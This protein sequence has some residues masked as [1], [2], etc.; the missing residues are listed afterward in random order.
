MEQ[1]L[2][3]NGAAMMAVP[4]YNELRLAYNDSY[5]Y[6]VHNRLRTLAQAI[7]VRDYYNKTNLPPYDDSTTPTMSTDSPGWRAERAGQQVQDKQLSSSTS[8]APNLS[9]ITLDQDTEQDGQDS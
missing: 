2:A 9:V 8:M 3:M 1:Q 5:W 4:L 6:R 7:Q